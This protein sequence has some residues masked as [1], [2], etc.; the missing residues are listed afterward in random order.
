MNGAG[1][2]HRDDVVDARSDGADDVAWVATCR[3]L[4]AVTLDDERQA[5]NVD[6]HHKHTRLL[7]G[8]AEG[9][10]VEEFCATVDKH[11]PCPGGRHVPAPM[12]EEV[13]KR[14]VAVD[15]EA[16]SSWL[17][18]EQFQARS[19]VGSSE[20]A[21]ATQIEPVVVARTLAANKT[22]CGIGRL[23]VHRLQGT[24]KSKVHVGDIE[25]SGIPSETCNSCHNLATGGD[26][27]LEN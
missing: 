9:G 16:P 1:V 12:L 4:D 10:V 26:D 8:G 23:L 2:V 19:A 13:C 25:Y 7:S 20:K 18:R 3:D 15:T 17:W 27:N 21:G 11:R 24:R 22:N 6:T 14:R 5:A